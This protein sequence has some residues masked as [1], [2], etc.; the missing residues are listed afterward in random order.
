[1]DIDAYKAWIGR[2]AQASDIIT[3]RL[4]ASFNAMLAPNVA[5]LADGAPAGLHWCLMP[6]IASAQRL[7][8]DGHPA[9]GDFLPPI[10]LPR[11]MWAAGDLTFL[12]PLQE[13]DTISKTSVIQSVDFKHGKTGPL[14]FVVVKHVISSQ[15]G[16]AIEEIQHIVYREAATAPA[17]QAIPADPAP[18]FQQ[19]WPVDI[20]PVLLFRYSALTFNGH[21]IHYDHPYATG[22]EFYDGLVIHGPLQATLMLNLACAQRGRLPKSF[23]FRAI[24]PAT[25]TQRL[26][27]GTM[28]GETGEEKLSILSEAG[29]ITMAGTARW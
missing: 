3:P 26:R 20:D 18:V 7:G 21:R 8:P 10:P 22:T 23:S 14:C 15:R 25:G 17:A 4:L 6:E 9:R 27:I 16:P 1:M 12:A 19:E 5:P 13:G 2:T 24:S 29:A 28:S 11:R